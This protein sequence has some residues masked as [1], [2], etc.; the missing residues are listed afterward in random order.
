MWLCKLLANYRL[1]AAGIDGEAGK[2]WIAAKSPV[3]F[4]CICCISLLHVSAA[5]ICCMSLRP[6]LSPGIDCCPERLLPR[7]IATQSGES[8]WSRFPRFFMSRSWP[9]SLRKNHLAW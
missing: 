5:C 2:L 9:G 3:F 8:T 6:V 7:L 1:F 4:A